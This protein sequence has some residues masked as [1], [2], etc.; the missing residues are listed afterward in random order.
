MKQNKQRKRA[1]KRHASDDETAPQ[2]DNPQTFDDSGTEER[3]GKVDTSSPRSDNNN[4][5][6]NFNNTLKNSWT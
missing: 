6:Y 1:A 4:Y 2:V 3:G 5:N